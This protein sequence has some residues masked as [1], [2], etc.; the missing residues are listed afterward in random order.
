MAVVFGVAVGAVGTVVVGTIAHDD[1]SAYS[2][3]GDYDNYSDA[4]ERRRRRIASYKSDAEAAASEL[5]DY[6]KYTVNPK[7]NSQAL[8]ERKAM[9]VSESSMDSDAKNKI[10]CEIE[11]EIAGETDDLKKELN[12]IDAL[13]EKISQIERGA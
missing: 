1:Y 5:S 6:K 2:E 12:Q 10:N 11:L 9:Q 7:L 8:K 4:A 13:L 3:Y